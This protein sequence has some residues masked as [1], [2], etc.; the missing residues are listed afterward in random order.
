M[1]TEQSR[2]Y[3]ENFHRDSSRYGVHYSKSTYFPMFALV[4]EEIKRRNLANILEVG[5]GSGTLAQF[6]MDRTLVRYR[7]FDF[8]A[9]A[10]ERA[11]KRVGRSDLFYVG[12]ARD[13][14]SYASE[15]EGIVCTEVLEHIEADLDVIRNW[16]SGA[17]CI[18]SV[19]N[20]MDESHVRVFKHEGRSECPLWRP[21]R[22]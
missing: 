3:Y 11:G 2:E 10:V 18:C 8:S 16:R 5:C 19:P 17:V 20:F 12:D 1:G 4:I 9:S 22:H 6:I 13:A 21:D 14:K 15:Y 7:G